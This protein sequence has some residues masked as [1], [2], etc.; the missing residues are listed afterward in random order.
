MPQRDTI[1]DAVLAMA[2][3][4]VSYNTGIGARSLK[5]PMRY[6]AAPAAKAALYQSL[7]DSGFLPTRIAEACGR[8]RSVVSRALGN[9]DGFARQY[10]CIKDARTITAN[11]IAL[12]Y[13]NGGE[14]GPA[15]PSTPVPAMVSVYDAAVAPI[16]QVVAEQR[17]RLVT[18]ADHN[19]AMARW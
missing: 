6:G 5:G 13:A 11:A 19:A 4:L 8:N 12:W 7:V 18:M 9:Y 3:H 16:R 15:T 17:R 1:P 14:D 2:Y 10:P